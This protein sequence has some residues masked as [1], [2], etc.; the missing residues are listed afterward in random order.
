MLFIVNLNINLG[1]TRC[2]NILRKMCTEGKIIS[3]KVGKKIEYK[4]LK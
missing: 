4:L 3:T 2:Y 1:P